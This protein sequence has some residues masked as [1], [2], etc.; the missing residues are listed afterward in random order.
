[1][2]GRQIREAMLSAHQNKREFNDDYFVLS[3]DYMDCVLESY[4]KNEDGTL[5]DKPFESIYN[6]RDK[7]YGYDGQHCVEFMD[8]K[9]FIVDRDDHDIK[10]EHNEKKEIFL[11]AIRHLR[12]NYLEEMPE[13]MYTYTN[14]FE[15]HMFASIK[16]TTINT[17]IF[18]N[19]RELEVLKDIKLHS[20]IN[21]ID[22]V[23]F[24]GK[25]EEPDNDI[26]VFT[27]FVKLETFNISK[28]EMHN[29]LRCVKGLD[30]FAI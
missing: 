18:K 30:R 7:V 10:E 17:G 8:D 20:A 21:S 22:S 9:I 27:F 2:R 15:D 19:L 26:V 11:D 12:D 24:I 1:M 14:V 16:A 3:N 5:K 29:T 25:D 6:T 13:A 23:F 28:L 4:F